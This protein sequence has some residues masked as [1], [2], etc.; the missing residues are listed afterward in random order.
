MFRN[1]Y[2]RVR[3]FANPGSPIDYEWKLDIDDSGR[4]R[5]VIA[6]EVNIYED[7]QSHAESV[8]IN[9][10]LSKYASGELL[11]LELR[12]SMYADVT[13]MPKDL[14]DVLRK[15]IAA[16]QY[17]EKLPLEER[18]KYDYDYGVFLAS[19]DKEDLKNES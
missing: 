2:D 12:E 5:L 18:A 10:I 9:V 6:R 19:A 14:A 7:I 3:C 15:N 17:F 8:D 13:E 1:S 16:Q 4:E 11:D